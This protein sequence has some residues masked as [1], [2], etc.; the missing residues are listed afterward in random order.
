MIVPNPTSSLMPNLGKFMGN[1]VN[2]K[3]DL[4]M[5]RRATKKMTSLDVTGIQKYQTSVGGANIGGESPGPG[6]AAAQ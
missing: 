3:K 1:K 4:T 2:L 6:V 5:M